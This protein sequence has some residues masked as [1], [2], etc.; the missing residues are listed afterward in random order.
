MAQKERENTPSTAAANKHFPFD[1][2]P[3]ELRISIYE[4]YFQVGDKI[5]LERHR[6]DCILPWRLR[7]IPDYQ[8]IYPW[9]VTI[10]LAA[11]LLQINRQTYDEA[12]PVLY[13]QNTFC[14]SAV[15]VL[16]HLIK[17]NSACMPHI[18]QVQ[19]SSHNASLSRTAAYFATNRA[20]PVKLIISFTGMRCMC[21]DQALTE[22]AYGAAAPYIF[23]PRDN[24]TPLERTSNIGARY[25]GTGRD[26]WP[27]HRCVR[28]DAA[29]Q[30]AKSQVVRT[31]L[32]ARVAQRIQD[33]AGG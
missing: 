2:L 10:G 19:I 23:C 22:S 14:F 13:G 32:K 1:K 7:I 3:A 27:C 26:Q 18:T 30:T 29:A 4:Y 33:E 6:G 16:R 21:V 9:Q 25:R 15:S 12:T 8:D 5:T 17:H 11:S 31:A 24:L 28:L 20:K